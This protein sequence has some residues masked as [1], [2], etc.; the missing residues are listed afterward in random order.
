M[1]HKCDIVTLHLSGGRPAL[2]GGAPRDIHAIEGQE[3]VLRVLVIGSPTPIVAWSRNKVDITTE[4]SNNSIIYLEE[5]GVLI[6]PHVEMR[7]SG[8]YDFYA[9]NNHGNETGSISLLVYPDTDLSIITTQDQTISSVP[10]PVSEFGCYVAN[11]HLF[12]NKKFREQFRV[13][14]CFYLILV[15]FSILTLIKKFWE[16]CLYELFVFALA[17][18][19][20]KNVRF[21]MSG[22]QRDRTTKCL[23]GCH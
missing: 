8:S 23:D 2:V 20:W 19:I 4:S 22:D 3:V 12:N 14:F 17:T 10:I 11:L 1:K 5:E 15:T 18:G 6:F 9:K 7:H 13:S 16:Q 21:G